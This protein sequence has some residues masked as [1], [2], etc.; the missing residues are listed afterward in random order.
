MSAI[1]VLKVKQDF[2][3]ELIFSGEW[4]LNNIVENREAVITALKKPVFNHLV[5]NGGQITRWDSQL[6]AFLVHVIEL[7]RENKID[8]RLNDFPTGIDSLLA[9]AFA[10]SVHE[11]SLKKD[12]RASFLEQLGQLFLTFWEKTKGVYLFSRHN[13][14]TCTKNAVS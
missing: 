9:L 4:L 12:R 7:C 8:F 11:E 1:V 10:V 5:L 3:A 14:I 2:S 13:S 6:T